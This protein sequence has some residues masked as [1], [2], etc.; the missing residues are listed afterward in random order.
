LRGVTGSANF[1]LWH[2]VRAQPGALEGTETAALPTF[3]AEC[4]FTIAFKGLGV[5]DATVA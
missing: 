2:N 1:G 4:R 5:A 3:G